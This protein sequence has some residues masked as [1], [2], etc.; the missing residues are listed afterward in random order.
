VLSLCRLH[1]F[2]NGKQKERRSWMRLVYAGFAK[3]HQ[4]GGIAEGKEH[5]LS[6]AKTLGCGFTVYL[7]KKRAHTS[8]IALVA[9]ERP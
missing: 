5:S 8:R 3:R 4:T 6:G 9:I 7:F 2:H 1:A